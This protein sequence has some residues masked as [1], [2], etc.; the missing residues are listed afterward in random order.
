MYEV[1]VRAASSS[2]IYGS[3]LLYGEASEVKR[4]SGELTLSVERYFNWVFSSRF[5]STRTATKSRPN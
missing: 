1:K 3:R 2:V 5:T 4:V